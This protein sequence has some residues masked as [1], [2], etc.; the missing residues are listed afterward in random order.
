MLARHS[1]VWLS[2]EGWQ[3]A[4]D[5]LPRRCHHAIEQWRQADWPATVRRADIDTPERQVCLGLALP[6][7]PVDGSKLRI[8]FRSCIAD[9]SKAL[10]PV[11]ID[12]VI[13]AVPETWRARLAALQAEIKRNAL[14]VKVYGSAALQALTGQR[15]V[16]AASDIDL[17][18]YPATKI[19]LSAGIDL[20]ASCANML[21]LDGE[22]VFPSGQAVA[23]KEWDNAARMQGNARVL[24]K[25]NRKVSL[26]TTTALLS[27]LQEP[28]H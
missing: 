10:D 27:T 20:L 15:Y 24:V 2:G 28:A 8:P 14:S 1:L 6:P 12:A 18:F 19:Q 11:G 17:L 23:W 5:T 9:V 26:A 21:P 22:I 16:T 13:D 25:D 3:K 4:L 7:D